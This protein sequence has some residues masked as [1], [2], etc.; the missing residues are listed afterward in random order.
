MNQNIS[1]IACPLSIVLYFSAREARLYRVLYPQYIIESTLYTN[2]FVS[3]R[4]NP[5]SLA[6]SKHLLVDI[7]LYLIK[8]DKQ[9]TSILLSM[10]SD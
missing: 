2:P 4:L 8:E 5:L 3:F 1:W 7:L 10:S 9:D 6:L